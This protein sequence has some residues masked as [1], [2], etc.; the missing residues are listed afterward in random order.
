MKKITYTLLLIFL[1]QTIA[2]AQ[3]TLKQTWESL[4]NKKEL[5]DF[6]KGTFERLGVYIDSTNEAFTVVHAG[7]HFLLENGIDSGKVDYIIQLKPENMRNMLRHGQDSKIDDEEAYKIMSVLFT[8]LTQSG[9]SNPRMNNKGLLKAIGIE[10]HLHVYL[11]SPDKK[12]YTAHTIVFVN[13][14]WLLIPGIVGKAQRT[15]IMY[16]KDAVEYQKELFAAQKNNTQ[17]SWKAFA[18]W[19]K[20]WKDKVSAKNN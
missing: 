17:T 7:D 12:E 8:P 4:L 16:P 15:F 14:Q 10:D 2:N 5:A 18:K 20:Q 1:L 19:F 13:K 11:F 6:F 9:L 3:T